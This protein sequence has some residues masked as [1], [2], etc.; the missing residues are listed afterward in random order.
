[1]YSILFY[2][3]LFF[4]ILASILELRLLLNFQN[5][6]SYKSIVLKYMYIL[7][8]RNY[9]VF[10][11]FWILYQRDSTLMFTTALFTIAKIWKQS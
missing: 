8:T 6:Y 7:W 1:M 5:I 11:L 10:K 4:K 3:G 2:G 9:Q